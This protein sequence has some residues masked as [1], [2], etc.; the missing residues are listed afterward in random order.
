[1]TPDPQKGRR[2][3]RQ[4]GQGPGSPAGDATLHLTHMTATQLTMKTIPE[5]HA[6]VQPLERYNSSI[7]EQENI[8]SPALPDTPGQQG[9]FSGAGVLDI[10][11]DG[12][13]FLRRERFL[14]GP[15][16]VYVSASQIRRF[17]LR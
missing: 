13:G 12:F 6:S 8:I 17:G 4:K 7:P 11:E 15:L 3:P 1:G 10:I 14:P 9:T 2:I 16:D 5:L